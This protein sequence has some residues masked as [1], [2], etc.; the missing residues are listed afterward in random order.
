MADE[1]MMD[2]YSVASF[3]IAKSIAE[4]LVREGVLPAETLAKAIRATVPGGTTA[5]NKQA[6]E[7][8][9]ALASDL[10]KN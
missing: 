5:A 10:G 4:T 2:A 8:M 6:I 3:L 9:N 1:V 7:I